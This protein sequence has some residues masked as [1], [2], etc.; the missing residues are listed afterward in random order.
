[1]TTLD[2]VKMLVNGEDT[3]AKLT[4]AYIVPVHRNRKIIA[5]TLVVTIKNR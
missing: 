5:I 2:V 1:M 3:E 4:T